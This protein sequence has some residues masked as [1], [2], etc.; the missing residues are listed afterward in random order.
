MPPSTHKA[1]AQN[2]ERI[3][4]EQNLHVNLAR[5]RKKQYLYATK[6]KQE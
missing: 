5:F 6:R 1:I 2:A 3:E 4:P